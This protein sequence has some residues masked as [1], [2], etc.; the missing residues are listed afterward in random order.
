[1]PPEI[2]AKLNHLFQGDLK[3]GDHLG[4]VAPPAEQVQ[5]NHR[6]DQQAPHT[7]RQQFSNF[8]APRPAIVDSIADVTGAHA[9]I[10]KLAPDPAPLGDALKHGLLEP[11]RLSCTLRGQPKALPGKSR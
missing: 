10:G 6:L 2:L 4:S 5:P 8:P 1:M 3:D 7:F 9:T 11:G